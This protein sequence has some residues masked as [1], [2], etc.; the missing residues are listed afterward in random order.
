MHGQC[1]F[2]PVDALPQGTDRNQLR[3]TCMI[4]AT[5]RVLKMYRTCINH[6]KGTHEGK[7]EGTREGR[8]V[9]TREGT[10]MGNSAVE[11][12]VQMRDILMG[13]P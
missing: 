11:Q 13:S 3:D 4:I 5:G 10:R 1:I 8:R 2:P 9:G 12:V 7:H 6:R